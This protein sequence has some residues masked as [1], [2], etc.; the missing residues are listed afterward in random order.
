MTSSRKPTMSA[1]KKAETDAILGFEPEP[2]G[3]L[4]PLDST[5]GNKW[6]RAINA[7]SLA[8]LAQIATDIESTMIETVNTVAKAR[9]KIGRLL[10]DARILFPGDKEFGQWRAKMVPDIKPRTANTYMRM[11]KEFKNG[12]DLVEK[13]G[14]SVARELLGAPTEVKESILTQL[15]DGD[16]NITAKEAREIVDEAKGK[17]SQSS[18]TEKPTTPPPELIE[19]ASKR[20][21]SFDQ[22]IKRI[23]NVKTSDRIA[24]ILAGELSELDE[25]SQS[26][27]IF[28]FSPGVLDHHANM[29]VWL[30]VYDALKAT[31]DEE[32]SRILDQAYTKVKEG[33]V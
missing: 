23:L 29:D 33:W 21:E 31:L 7:E 6:E 4:A 8:S 30:T 28:G 1:E 13:M 16:Y 19:P 14:W 10:N 20:K 25:H 2:Q 26:A 5:K 12:P 3:S 24:A 15:D 27:I 9:L 11:A 17:P 18:G 22:T 32:D